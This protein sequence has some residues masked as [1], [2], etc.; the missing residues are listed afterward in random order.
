MTPLG[1][2]TRYDYDEDA[3][4]KTLTR[5]GGDTVTVTRDAAGRMGSMT[6]GAGRR[7][8]PMTRRGGWGA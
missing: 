5:P 6:T 3:Q 2:T 7:L 8:T 4:L 1:A